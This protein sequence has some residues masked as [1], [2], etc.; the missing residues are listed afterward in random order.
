MEQQNKILV[1]SAL[2]YANGPIHLGH[3]AGAYLPADIYVRYQR[4]RRRDVV[5]IC[6][7]DEHGVPITIAAERQGISPQQV[8]DKYYKI[9]RESFEKVG[10]S[11]DNYSRTSLPIHH[12]NSQEFF[13]ALHKK[14]YLSEQTVTQFFCNHCDRFLADRYVEGTCPICHAA[15]ARGDQCDTCG[16]SLDQ[17]HLIDP[18]CVT[19]GNTPVIRETR[20]W[21]LN[22]KQLQPQIKAWLDTKTHWKENVR[23]FCEGWFK[24]GLEDRAV[25]RDLRWGVQVPLKGYENKVLYVWFDAPIGYISSTIEWAQKIGQPEKWKDYWLDPSTSMVHFIGKDNI[26]FH[27]I[28][29]PII[30]MGHGGYVLPAEIPANEYLTLEGNKISTSKNYA[31]WLDEYLKIFP[32]DPLRYCIAINAPETKDADF[33][34]R[35]FQQRNNNELAD[36]LGNFV[37][38]TLTFLKKH[39]DNRAPQPGNFDALDEEMLKRLNDAPEK[40]GNLFEKFEVRKATATIMD[41]ARFANKYFNDQQPWVTVTDAPEK[42]A[43]TF[44]VAVQVLKGLAILMEPV[45]PFSARKLWAMVNLPGSL[46]E[47]HWSGAGEANVPVGHPLAKAKILFAKIEDEIIEQQIEKLKTMTV[48][49]DVVKKET[50]VSDKIPYEDF[51]K[52]QLRI[53]K[54]LHAE[55][56]EKTEK[57]MKMQI[58]LGTEQR[59]IVAGIALKYAPDDLI[60]KQVVVV[61]NLEPATIRGI[62]SNGM[63]LAA[64]NEDGEMALLIPDKEITNG[65]KIK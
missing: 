58:D 62:E 60:G 54:I 32:P 59:Q 29:W 34:W 33:S 46:E 65:S 21:F 57:L 13:L 27:A 24:T 51:Q 55:K 11:F 31:V 25:T 2:P 63:L 1:T 56:V 14:G 6:G 39:F 9:N 28:I 3:L 44:F 64:S 35:D 5:Y 22:L 50:A 48:K 12:K 37:N 42:C 43:T 19:C 38:R 45:L 8:V 15:G 16:R 53:A 23:N 41:L 10:V 7:S 61:A 18:I 36:I 26:V 49:A 52:V 4:L 17:T 30:L 47:Q 20:H 40:I